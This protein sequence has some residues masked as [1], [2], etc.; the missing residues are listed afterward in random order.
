M[1]VPQ[2]LYRHQLRV[3]R[4]P[5]MPFPGETGNDHAPHRLNP[6]AGVF[7][8]TCPLFQMD[9]LSSDGYPRAMWRPG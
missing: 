9:G 1:L 2:G 3:F 7:C 6:P 4:D 8:V 5:A